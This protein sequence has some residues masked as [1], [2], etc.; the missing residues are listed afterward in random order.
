MLAVG[1][2]KRDTCVMTKVLR[3]ILILSFLPMLVAPAQA[4]TKSDLLI[5]AL[6]KFNSSAK[7]N[8]TK[9]A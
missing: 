4:A 8:Y 3:S 9:S 2:L 1:L 6:S 7:E 5:Q